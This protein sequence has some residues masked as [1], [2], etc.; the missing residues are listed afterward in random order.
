MILSI[1][2]RQRVCHCE[3]KCS[4]WTI[5]TRGGSFIPGNFGP[6][7]SDILEI[8]VWGTKI[9]RTKTPVTEQLLYTISTGFHHSVWT[10]KTL[11]LSSRVTTL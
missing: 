9:S 7:G 1:Y 11:S 2:T 3:A 8:L 6:C 4:L 5:S 10:N